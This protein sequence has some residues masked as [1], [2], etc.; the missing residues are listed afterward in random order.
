MPSRQVMTD[1]YKKLGDTAQI[2][3]LG[4]I[5]HSLTV[6]ARDT[7]IP[8]TE[9]I[10]DPV[11]L[12]GINE[13]QHRIAGQLLSMLDASSDRYPDE[14]FIE[15]LLSGL[16]GLRCPLSMKQLEQSIQA[17]PITKDRVRKLR[18][19]A[20]RKLKNGKSPLHFR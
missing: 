2:R 10:A 3:L 8:G 6:D 9:G 19:Q 7:Y 20:V 17:K 13:L 4:A 12:R 16:D 5:A 1:N 18:V 11:R 14:V 15:I